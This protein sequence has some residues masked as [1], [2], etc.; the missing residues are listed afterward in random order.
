[1]GRISHF[2]GANTL[3]NVKPLGPHRIFL[4]ICAGATRPLSRACLRRGKC[5]L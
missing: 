4:D 1:M 2:A 3:G 5:V